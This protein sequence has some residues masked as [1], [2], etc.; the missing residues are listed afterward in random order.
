MYSPTSNHPNNHQLEVE[1]MSTVSILSSCVH[2]VG[3]AK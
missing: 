1:T 3:E 2:H